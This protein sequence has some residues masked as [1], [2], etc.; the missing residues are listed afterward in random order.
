MNETALFTAAL[1]EIITTAPQLLPLLWVLFRLERM[2]KASNEMLHKFCRPCLELIE[3]PDP[4]GEDSP[5][6]T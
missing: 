2:L 1:N 3:A 5:T 6:D 4:Q